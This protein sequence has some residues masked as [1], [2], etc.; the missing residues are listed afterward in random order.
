MPSTTL[1]LPDSTA[2]FDD[3]EGGL[4]DN[5]FPAEAIVPGAVK[6]YYND[7]SKLSAELKMAYIIMQMADIENRDIMEDHAA[8]TSGEPTKPPPIHTPKSYVAI[9][10]PFA[11]IKDNRKKAS[12][13]STLILPKKDIAQ[14]IMRRCT[15]IKGVNHNNKGVEQ[16]MALLLKHPITDPI[17]IAF[18]KNEF[19]THCSIINELLADGNSKRVSANKIARLRFIVILCTH[20]D[21]RAAYLRSTDG[22]TAQEI[23]YQ[24]SDKAPQSWMDLL[25]ILF[26]D[27]SIEVLTE[28]NLIFRTTV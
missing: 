5:E 8:A 4:S 7:Q 3:D 26:N 11:S 1:A 27:P 16:L 25:C 10:E 23:D 19:Q 20:D 6:A 21:V 12:K 17:D 13:A 22:K 14:E 24:N 2:P 9:T 28:V 18:I 15:T